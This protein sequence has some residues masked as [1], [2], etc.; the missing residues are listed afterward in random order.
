MSDKKR[1]IPVGR[2]GPGMGFDEDAVKKFMRKG[3]KSERDPRGKR[4]KRQDRK[5]R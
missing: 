3:V 4:Q 1:S 5:S 2:F